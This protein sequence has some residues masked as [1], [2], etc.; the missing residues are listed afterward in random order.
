MRPSPRPP[1]Y[2]HGP[3]RLFLGATW[4]LFAVFAGAAPATS[5]TPASPSTNTIITCVNGALVQPTNATFQG[6]VR[7]FDPQLYLECDRLAVYFPSNNAAGSLQAGATPNLGSIHSVVAEGNLLMMLRGATLIGDRAVYSA[8]N[9]II[10]I[11]GGIVVIETENGYAYGTNFIFN[12]Q[13]MELRSE[14]PSTLESKPGVSLMD[15]T[16][17]LSSPAVRPRRNPA[18]NANPFAPRNP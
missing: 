11:T 4:A 3:A 18:P 16:N 10:H 14:G 8:T 2:F 15:G 1:R 7:V 17:T 13:T 6:S 5:T 12:R 9:D